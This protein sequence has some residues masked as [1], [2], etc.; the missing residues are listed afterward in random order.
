M[1]VRARHGPDP[2][3]KPVIEGSLSARYYGRLLAQR[4]FGGA[5]E[6]RTPTSAMRRPR[7][8]VYTFAPLARSRKLTLL[9]PGSG[10]RGRRTLVSTMPLSR[11]TA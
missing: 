8:P 3:D 6:N 7:T 4:T 10:D 9:A 1:R 5:T 11:P 2:S